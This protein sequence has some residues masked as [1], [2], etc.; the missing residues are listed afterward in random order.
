M[1][2]IK[3]II[4]DDESRIRR[5]LE[6][7]VQACGE[8]WEIINLFSDGKE[9]FDEITNQ[10][11]SFDLLITDVQMPEMDGLT[12][13]SELK[14]TH[15]FTSIIISGYDDFTYLQTAMREGAVNYILKPVDKR[16]FT[17]QLEEVKVKISA[18]RMEQQKWSEIHGKAQQLIYTKQ[19]QLLSEI[20]WND[21]MDL[22]VIDWTKQFPDG[23][24]QLLY[25]SVDQ[26]ISAVENLASTQNWDLKMEEMFK[27]ISQE[28]AGEM[29]YWWWRSGKLQYWILICISDTNHFK[30]NQLVEQYKADIQKLTP[31]TISIGVANHF[32]EIKLLP[33]VKDQ[34]LTLLQYRMIHGGNKVYHQNMLVDLT[35]NSQPKNVSSII[36]KQ[37]HQILSSLDGKGEDETVSAVHQLFK[38]LESISSPAIIE[39]AVHYLCLQIFNKW[40]EIDGFGE[41]AEMLSSALKVTKK[42]GNFTQLKDSI[43][44]WVVD[45]KRKVDSR[46]KIDSDPILRAKK[47]IHENLGKHITIKEIAE[48]IYMSPTY[49]SNYFKAQTGETILDYITKCRL[50]KAKELLETTDTKVYDISSKLGYQDTKYFSRLFKQ[51]YGQ[52]PSQYREYHF[53]RD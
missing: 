19:I 27:Q 25:V 18:K 31:F 17:E 40:M 24:Y 2:S 48:H 7:L 44:H 23:V 30:V 32:Q 35:V 6:R 37:V 21:A 51:W 11:I 5:R 52:S 46:R 34:L 39:D 20:T 50:E 36:Y 38:E 16:K 8:E 45:I 13:I 43:K 29:D 41:N 47:W 1:T 15:S 28:A 4:V 10:S 42:A 9:A 14:K 3:T 26:N 12:L 49:F 53:K 33:S 22:S